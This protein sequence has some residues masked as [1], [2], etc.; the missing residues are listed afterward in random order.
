MNTEEIETKIRE[1]NKL[2]SDKFLTIDDLTDGFYNGQIL[3]Y[4]KWL[5]VLTQKSK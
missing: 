1:L 4:E 2:K 3:I 5:K